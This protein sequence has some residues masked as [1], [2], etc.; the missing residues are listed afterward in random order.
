VLLAATWVLRAWR[1]A[2]VRR[3]AEQRQ[4]QVTQEALAYAEGQFAEIQQ[5]LTE[6]AQTVAETPVVGRVLRRRQEEREASVRPLVRF[7]GG[8]EWATGR[9]AVEIYDPLPRVVAWRGFSVPLGDAPD[10]L[11]FL[12]APQTGVAGSAG[13]RRALVA[14][15][16]VREG[17]RVVGGVR[18]SKTVRFRAPVQNEY[19]QSYSLAEQWS[20]ATGREMTV[21]YGAERPDDLPSAAR[22][23]ALQS[24]SGQ[25]LA[26]VA[27][28]PPAPEQ[29]ARAVQARYGDW[30][31]LW[32]ALLATLGAAG[33]WTWFGSA[34]RRAGK[35][36]APRRLRRLTGRL[37]VASAAWWGLRYALLALDVPARWGEDLPAL[38]S[39]FAPAQLASTIG[40][41][42][43]R[44]TGDL[45]ITGVFAF[46][47]AAAVLRWG[48]HF[49]GQFRSAKALRAALRDE[50]R[51]RPAPVRALAALTGTATA[52]TALAAGL[53]VLTR[54]VVIDST[55]DFFAH[56]GLLP[57]PLLLVVFCALLLLAGAALLASAGLV[58]AARWSAARWAPRLGEN[59]A[60]AHRWHGIDRR[61]LGWGAAVLIVLAAPLAARAALG[62]AAG[63]LTVAGLPLLLGGTGVALVRMGLLGPRER[64]N[65]LTLRWL[66]PGVLLLAVALYPVLY[67]GMHAQRQARLRSAANAFAEGGDP[68][69]LFSLEQVLQEAREAPGLHRL[70]RAKTDSGASSTGASS[71]GASSPGAAPALDSTGAALLRG[72]LL[73]SLSTY[74]VNMVLF[75]STGVPVGQYAS[76]PASPPRSAS[77]GA[78]LAVLRDMYRDQQERGPFVK[79]MTGWPTPERFQYA[80][81][82]PVRRAAGTQAAAADTAAA[83]AP[84]GWLVL[85]AVPQSFRADAGTPF[86]RALLPDAYYADLYAEVALAE[87]Q[88]GA[89]VRN[90]GRDFGRV[91]LPENVRA[92]LRA[93]STLWR[94]E[95]SEGRTTLTFYQQKPS[96]T[97][98]R[99]AFGGVHSVTAVRVPAT[100]TFDH[101]YYALRLVMAGLLVAGPLYGMGLVLRWRAGLLPAPRVRFRHKVLNALLGVG[102]VAVAVVGLVGLRVLTAEN[103]RATQQWLRQRLEQVEETLAREAED[104]EQLYEVAQRVGIDRL[105]A[106]VGLDLN[107]Y[108]GPRLVAS[109][110]PRLVEE[111]LIDRRLPI[112]AYRA[113]YLRG[114]R[115]AATQERIGRFP[116]MAGFR[117][118]TDAQGAPRFVLSAPT[119]PEQERIADEQSRTVAYLFGALLVL[120]LLVTVTALVLAG[121]LTRPLRRLRAGLEAVGK[122]EFARALPIDTR[123]EI[124]DLAETFN[125][126]RAQ[127]AE[128]RRKLAQQERELA[129]REMARQVAHEIK[130][131]LTPMKLSVQHL[132]RAFERAGLEK[133]VEAPESQ[134]EGVAEEEGDGAPS[135]DGAPGESA[136]PGEDGT[137]RFAELFERITST[138]IEQIDGLSRIA[139]EFSSFGRMPTRVT[140]PLDLSETV[141]AATSLMQE[142]EPGAEIRLQLAPE[143]LVVEADAEELRRLYINLI[144]NAL[145]ALPEGPAGQREGRVAVATERA[146]NGRARSTVT[147]NGSGIPE[148]LR[149]KI[150]QPSFS[151]KTSGMGLGLAIAKK[152]VE[153]L[154]GD[155]GFDTERGA[156]TTFWIELPLAEQERAA[157]RERE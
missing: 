99:S 112:S 135:G 22:T 127:L 142:E 44:S 23:R 111:R 2:A 118:L 115:F 71:P 53:T 83:A 155:I 51:A 132:R 65:L 55:F 73:S 84:A 101:L 149:E 116:Y 120:I 143:P 4:E 21:H 1:G 102:A 123:D 148:D 48:G 100:T 88:N 85:R 133:E 20:Q 119:L 41:G 33:L 107:L 12:E 90:L 128:S 78:E 103:E 97:D 16:P 114:E 8:L 82:L 94:T 31:A 86:P 136:P 92:T 75:D 9:W 124:G 130:N 32:V 11:R 157:E 153:E 106:R 108:E 109:S 110:R 126:M 105:A 64:F 134:N 18:V 10:A 49:W 63:M 42:A 74:D 57:G 140:E 95:Q 6:R 138:L 13:A 72:S 156:G 50:D 147:D 58:A 89:L 47:F 93:D 98:V 113:L 62:S 52:V 3:Q 79:Q 80:G 151:T 131:P 46:G 139:D 87:F 117:A 141:E 137:G 43:L 66:L 28:T 122:G 77:R 15:H 5:E 29:L 25:T 40:A 26:H 17:G 24:A 81:L 19:L 76:A 7:A 68:R 61:R 104:G 38:A 27:L 56:T 60:G 34:L 129:W 59:T 145:Q 36:P 125:E 146:E 39:L 35:T 91:R 54:R 144:K 69:V 37:A 96:A 30:M 152:S 154:G 67:G 150:F 45:L 70:L 14:W 121:A